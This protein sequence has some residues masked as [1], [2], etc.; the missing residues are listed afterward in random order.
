MPSNAFTSTGQQAMGRH[1]RRRRVLPEPVR[2]QGAA[3]DAV[4]HLVDCLCIVQ[5]D[6]CFR[7]R[8]L[9]LCKSS[10][11]L[12]RA[13]PAQACPGPHE[14]ATGHPSHP[15]D[16]RT[17][18]NYALRA[19]AARPAASG[20]LEALA[21]MTLRRHTLAASPAKARLPRAP[22]LLPRSLAGRHS[23]SG[24]RFVHRLRSQLHQRCRANSSLT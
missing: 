6:C 22:R 16:I 24:E 7:F 23:A 4:R 2:H 10:L 3:V 13:I 19:A 21:T 5:P 20:L 18:G 8:S 12:T 17:R 1:D 9:A 11:L 14:V 15:G